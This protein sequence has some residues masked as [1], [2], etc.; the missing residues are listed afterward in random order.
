MDSNKIQ[1]I[2]F[3]F[4]KKPRGFFSRQLGL[5]TCK[6]KCVPHELKLSQIIVSVSCNNHTIAL[7]NSNEIY[8]WGRNHYGQLGLGHKN[9]MYVPSKLL[10]DEPIG[11]VSCGQRHTVALTKSGKCYMWG[12]HENMKIYSENHNGMYSPQQIKFQEPIVS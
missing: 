7:T 1:G 12:L 9:N 4:E 6:Q 8:V 11:S 5:G 10:M 3:E 2:L